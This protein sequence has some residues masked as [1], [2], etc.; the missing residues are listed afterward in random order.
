MGSIT[1]SVKKDKWE[2]FGGGPRTIQF[3]KGSGDFPTILAKGKI[4]TVTIGEGMP[5]DSSELIVIFEIYIKVG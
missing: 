2:K 3:Q 4:L 5:P 1:V